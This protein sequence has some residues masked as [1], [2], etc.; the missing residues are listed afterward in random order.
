MNIYG[1]YDKLHSVDTTKGIVISRD[2][3]DNKYLYNYLLQFFP[4]H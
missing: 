1:I 3:A 4:K 2:D